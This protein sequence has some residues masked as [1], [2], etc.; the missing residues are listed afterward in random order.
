MFRSCAKAPVLLP[1]F[2]ASLFAGPKIDFDVRTFDCGTVIEGKT[3]KL[4]AVF[5]VKNKGNALLKLT[6]VKP[7]CG[8]TVVKYDSLIEPGKSVK[9][10][11]QVNINGYHSGSISKFITVTSNADS[12]QTVRL[13][14]TANIQSIVDVSESYINLES[15][16]IK[17]PKTLLLSSKKRDLQVSDV[18]FKPNAQ[19][20][21][22][23]WKNIPV[24]IKYKWTP[25][26]SINPDGCQVY[27]LELFSPGAGNTMSGEFTIKTNH[28]DKPAITVTGNIVK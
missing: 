15:S 14:I 12:E 19:P 1:L 27:R 25:L 5:T 23:E 28:S 10:E 8:C 4:H 16:N 20:N 11:S 9:I 21:V 18:S 17:A 22:P 7:G 24:T 3:E 13:T 6:N 26:D 2:V